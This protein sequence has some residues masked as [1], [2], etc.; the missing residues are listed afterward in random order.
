MSRPIIW[1]LVVFAAGSLLLGRLLWEVKAPVPELCFI[2]FGVMCGQWGHHRCL[3]S[4]EY[5]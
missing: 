4:R 3:A 2:A 5:K 1:P